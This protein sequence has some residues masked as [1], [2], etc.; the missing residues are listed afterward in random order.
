[1]AT[2]KTAKKTPAKKLKTVSK[3]KTV[4]VKAKRKYTRKPKTEPVTLDDVVSAAHEAGAKVEVA[5]EQ[6]NDQNQDAQDN[7]GAMGRSLHAMLE[8]LMARRERAEMAFHHRVI[9]AREALNSAL[10]D[11]IKVERDNAFIGAMAPGDREIME[12][13]VHV[14]RLKYDRALAQFESVIRNEG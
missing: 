3:K 11:L 14:A 5:I 1:M 7:R 12:A 13:E 2:K 8:S 10:N 9:D 4:E 6:T